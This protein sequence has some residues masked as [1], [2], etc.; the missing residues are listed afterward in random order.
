M[1]DVFGR[2]LVG[3]RDHSGLYHSVLSNSTA[4]SSGREF[5]ENGLGPGITCQ[6]LQQ[7]TLQRIG[8]SRVGKNG[9]AGLGVI[10]S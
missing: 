3:R 5:P 1:R 4:V 9:K 2:F 10:I 7:R 6:T 8:R